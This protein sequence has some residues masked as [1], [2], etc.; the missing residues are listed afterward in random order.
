MKNIT[1]NWDYRGPA[2]IKGEIFGWPIFKPVFLTTTLVIMRQKKPA[3]NISKDIIL[4][5]FI[6]IYFFTFHVGGTGAT[7]KSKKTILWTSHTSKVIVFIKDE[8]FGGKP[9]IF[10]NLPYLWLLCPQ[11][12]RPTTTKLLVDLYRFYILK[13]QSCQYLESWLSRTH[14]GPSVVENFTVDRK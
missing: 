2:F 14:I 4:I 7:Y 6:V 3:S 12:P 9:A 8:S 13:W 5:L 11:L 10:A 1:G